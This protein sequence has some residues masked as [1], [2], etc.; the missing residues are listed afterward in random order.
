MNSSAA[1]Q[2][3]AEVKDM[4]FDRAAV[5]NAISAENRRKLSRVGAFVRQRARTDILRRPPKG[6]RHERP[7]SQPGSPPFVHAPSGA[8]ASLKNILFAL[9]TDWESVIIGPRVVP[10]RKIRGSQPTV[11]ALLEH[12]G[13]QTITET[14]INGQW[15][16]GFRA[17][18]KAETARTRR[19]TA[20]YAARPFMAPALTRT[21][22]EGA[23]PDIWKK[24]GR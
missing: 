14:F 13:S 16:P 24:R 6:R 19:R 15:I 1:W 20:K 8:F 12:G 23:I 9:N 22:G 3:T 4:F 17:M 10:S 7:A 18:G 11:P 2:M 21:I 5:I